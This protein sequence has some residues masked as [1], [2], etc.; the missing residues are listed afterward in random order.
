MVLLI[1]FFDKHFSNDQMIAN[2]KLLH[3]I[4]K[5]Y[6]PTVWENNEKLNFNQAHANQIFSPRG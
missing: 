5:N 3:F 4:Q 1:C 6:K 2:M